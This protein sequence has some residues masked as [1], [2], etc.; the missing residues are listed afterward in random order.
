MES[1]S[2]WNALKE[3]LTRKE[4]ETIKSI[5]KQALMGD[6]LEHYG[7]FLNALVMIR[8]EVERLDADNKRRQ[9]PPTNKRY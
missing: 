2:K 6:P 1:D 7:A 9:T 5:Y 4:T 3:Y 8:T